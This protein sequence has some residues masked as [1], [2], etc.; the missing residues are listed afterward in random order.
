MFEV[1][2][3]YLAEISDFINYMIDYIKSIVLMAQGKE[4]PTSAQ[5]DEALLQSKSLYA[6]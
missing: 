2:L 6:D 4:E 5:D 1:L 3:G